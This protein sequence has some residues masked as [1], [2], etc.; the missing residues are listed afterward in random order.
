MIHNFA[1]RIMTRLQFEIS[2]RRHRLNDPAVFIWIPK[3]AGSSIFRALRPF[4]CRRINTLEKI[5][6]EFDS[7]GCVTF[8]H[9]GYASLVDNGAVADSFASEAFCFSFVRNPFDRAVSLWAYLSR[10]GLFDEDLT[11]D[12]FVELV[13]AGVA[14]VGLY[15]TNGLSQANPQIDWFGGPNHPQPDFVGRY[16]SLQ[17]DFAIVCDHLGLPELLLPH[18]NPSERSD[19]RPYFNRHTRRL[20]ERIYER[21]FE[22]FD[23]SF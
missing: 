18:H 7:R 23:Y 21:D 22:A 6:G 16:E 19:Y 8:G 4:G 14:P 9:I 13:E 3:V 15:N 17:S 5:A 20:V 12:A 11:F 1:S 10:F 2:T